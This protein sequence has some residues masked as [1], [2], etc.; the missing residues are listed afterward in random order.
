MISLRNA[1]TL[2]KLDT[3]M[4]LARNANP[5]THSS[6]GNG[7]KGMVLV[8]FV[9]GSMASATFLTA[10]KCISADQYIAVM[11]GL[12]GLIGGFVIGKKS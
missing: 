8:L 12:S 5:K 6:T 10:T 4:L 9:V 7:S 3:D 11:S 2:F 1:W